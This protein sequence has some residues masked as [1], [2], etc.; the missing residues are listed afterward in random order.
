MHG[1]EQ[2]TE[3]AMDPAPLEAL[4][5]S[6]P[7]AAELDPASLLPACR[8]HRLATASLDLYSIRIPASPGRVTCPRCRRRFLAAGPTGFADEETICDPCLLEADHQLGM[9]LALVAISRA[10]GASEL[11]TDQDYWE[12]ISELGAFARIYERFAARHGPA[13]SFTAP[14]PPADA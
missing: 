2:A 10:F 4:S 6:L 1:L 3:Q 11:E 9:V 13:R 14:D 7:A 8:E 12:A 5:G